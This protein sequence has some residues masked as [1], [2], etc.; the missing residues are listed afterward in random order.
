MRRKLRELG[1]VGFMDA[2]VGNKEDASFARC[3]REAA[4][5]RQEFFGSGHIKLPTRLHEILLRVHFPEDHVFRD[6]L[7]FHPSILAPGPQAQES[8][9]M[10]GIVALRAVPPASFG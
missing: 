5:I 7:I 4:K 1:I 8:G 3:V 9:W 2:A 6:R 10:P